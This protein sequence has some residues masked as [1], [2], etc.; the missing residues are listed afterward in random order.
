MALIHTYAKTKKFHRHAYCWNFEVV[1]SRLHQW[2]GKVVGLKRMPTHKECRCDEFYLQTTEAW[3]WNWLVWRNH[4]KGHSPLANIPKC[5]WKT[6]VRQNFGEQTGV[7]SE[8]CKWWIERQKQVPSGLRWWEMVMF[9]E[10]RLIMDSIFKPYWRQTSSSC[11]HYFSSI[12][13]QSIRRPLRPFLVKI[14]EVSLVVVRNAMGLIQPDWI[15]NSH[16]SFGSNL[17]YNPSMRLSRQSLYDW[18]DSLSSS[19]AST[20]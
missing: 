13:L 12:N 14:K 7:L 17:E 11:N 6:K 19:M 20:W 10:P 18:L 4:A 15:K 2:I 3:Q 5:P 8:M 16:L 9:L 1:K